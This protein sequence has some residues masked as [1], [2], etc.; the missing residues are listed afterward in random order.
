[1]EQ[2]DVIVIGSGV[3]GGMVSRRLAENGARVL[4]V[5]RGDFVP[6]EPGN[7]SVETVFFEKKYKARDTWL[8]RTGRPFDPGMYYNV[9]GATKFYGGAM[10]RLRERD[11]EDLEHK[12][13]VSPAWP[14]R[15]ADLAPYYDDAE[16]IFRVHG[17]ESQD[18]TSPRG[19]KP[20]PFPAVASEPIVA[21]MAEDFR[22]QGLSP[23]A[24]AARGELRRRRHLHPLQHM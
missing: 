7:W 18:K 10:F 2:P 24:H 21:K 6:R 9:G 16:A 3:G 20:F 15:Y 5:E 19:G 11:F 22:R 23:S 13:G 4:M 1:M 8:D 14:I 17:D 12:G